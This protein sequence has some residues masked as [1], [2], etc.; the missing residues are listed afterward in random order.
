VAAACFRSADMLVLFFEK[1]RQTGKFAK[2]GIAVGERSFR[3]FDAV[4]KRAW[5]SRIGRTVLL[6]ICRL[7]M[8]L[9][10]NNDLASR[11]NSRYFQLKLP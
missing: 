2:E 11:S 3:A 8:H 9:R 6:M 4:M 7:I 10:G 5:K 1:V